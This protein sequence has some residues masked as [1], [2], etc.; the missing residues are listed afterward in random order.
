MKINVGGSV[1]FIG[2]GWYYSGASQKTTLLSVNETGT[3]TN[4]FIIPTDI[5]IKVD[6]TSYTV[7][8]AHVKSVIA[9]RKAAGTEPDVADITQ[10]YHY[11]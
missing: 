7:V 11:H 6:K 3:D 5:Q 10:A 2:A 8:G 1:G 4:T 9:S